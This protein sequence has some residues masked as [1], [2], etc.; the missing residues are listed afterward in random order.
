MFFKFRSEEAFARII[1]IKIAKLRVFFKYDFAKTQVSVCG[2]IKLEA[3]NIFVIPVLLF[4][5]F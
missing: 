3:I 4:N 1:K 2:I 5:K